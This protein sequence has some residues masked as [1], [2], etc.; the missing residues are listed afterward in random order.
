MDTNS[1]NSRLSTT[2][3]YATIVATFY[4]YSN[5]IW[6]FLPYIH[7]ED[8]FQHFPLSPQSYGSVRPSVPAALHNKE[9]SWSLDFHMRRDLVVM[10]LQ[11]F[12]SVE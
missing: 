5:D 4:L 3:K 6:K 11:A 8:I 9:Q 10:N 1:C 2:N 12:V 7:L